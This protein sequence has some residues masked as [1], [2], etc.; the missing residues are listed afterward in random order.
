MVIPKGA[1]FIVKLKKQE[2]EAETHPANLSVVTLG[3]LFLEVFPLLELFGVWEGNAV[4]SLE[5]LCICFAF[6]V[7]GRVLGKDKETKHS[8]IYMTNYLHNKKPVCI[9]S[10]RKRTHAEQK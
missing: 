2:G 3:R 9:K 6:P 4:N 5:G 7:G 1:F 10:W 8:G